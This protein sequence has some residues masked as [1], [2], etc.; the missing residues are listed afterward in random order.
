MSKVIKLKQSDLENI[1][2]N[3][4]SQQNSHAEEVKE[5]DGSD[6]S[7]MIIGKNEFGKIVVINK[8]TGEVIGTK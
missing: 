2:E 1:I 8:N 3:I 6:D 7:D 5:M 4:I